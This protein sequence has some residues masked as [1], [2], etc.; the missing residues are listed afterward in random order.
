M[1]VTLLK[2][3]IN[4]VHV[5]RVMMCRKLVLLFS[6]VTLVIAVTTA[7]AKQSSEQKK[8]SRQSVKKGFRNV[9]L[10]IADDQGLDMGAYGNDA[11]KTPNLDK[12]AKEGTTFTNGFATVSSCSPSRSVIYSGLYSHTNGM[13]GLA[14]DIHNQH[15]L[16]WVQTIP[17]LLKRNGYSTCLIG[18][19]HILP[20]ES[21]PFD[22]E[23]VPEKPGP[24]NVELMADDAGKFLHAHMK[25]PFFLVVAFSDPHRAGEGFGSLGSSKST[26]YD[27]S[28]VIVPAHLPDLSAVREDLCHYYESISRLDRGVGLVED[29]LKK[30]GL[31]E[32]T[33]VIYL[34]DN[35]RPFPGAKTTLYDEGIHLPLIVVSP[36]QQHRGIR[37][38]A[39][40]SWIDIVPTILQWTG[41]APPS[42]KLPGHSLLSILDEEHSSDWER[43][44][45]SHVLHEINQYYPMRAIRTRQYEYIANLAY[46]LPYPVSTDIQQSPTW[47]AILATPSAQLGHRTLDA[48]FHR[49]Q[50]ELYDVQKD[51]EEVHNLAGDPSYQSVVH[52]MRAQLRQFQLATDD[53]WLAPH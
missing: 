20:R 42:Y 5:S 21:L 36:R 37:N 41:A 29:E 28:R 31:D 45:A 2:S 48:F 16:P 1:M 14:H 27:P 33:L 40:V 32:K 51:P 44:Y 43:I 35:G 30:Y 26:S 3:S 7:S 11:I 34:S 6:L 52:Q 49:P 18:K 9:L 15:L 47:K 19:K 12:L 24:R 38:D 10:I 46:Q 23:L 4:P 50:E 25:K 13:Y 17:T 53:P 8:P 39:M 22:Q